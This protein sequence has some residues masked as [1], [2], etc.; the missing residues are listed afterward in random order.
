MKLLMSVWL[1]KPTPI[2]KPPPR[3]VNAV[4]GTPTV[5][6]AVRATN[7]NRL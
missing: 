2:A 6:N 4:I 1:P 7:I 5:L 3:I